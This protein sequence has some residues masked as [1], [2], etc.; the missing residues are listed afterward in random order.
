MQLKP[1]LVSSL[2]KAPLFDGVVHGEVLV[3]YGCFTPLPLEES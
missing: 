3:H 2:K 1:W